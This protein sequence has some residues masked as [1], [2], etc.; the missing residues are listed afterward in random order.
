MGYTSDQLALISKTRVNDIMNIVY[1]KKIKGKYSLFTACEPIMS[2]LHEKLKKFENI[3]TGGTMGLYEYFE[4]VLLNDKYPVLIRLTSETGDKILS[5]HF[6]TIINASNYTILW[7][8][9]S[10]KD[11]LKMMMEEEKNKR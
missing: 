3:R 11:L 2:K 6:P 1:E 4:I 5:M 8:I 9:Y 7:K 10:A